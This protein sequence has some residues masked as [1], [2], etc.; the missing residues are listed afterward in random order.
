MT[1]LRDT[2]A[3]SDGEKWAEQ[4]RLA[5]LDGRALLDTLELPPDDMNTLLIVL[6]AAYYHWEHI[7]GIETWAQFAK[8]KSLKSEG[9]D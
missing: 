8:P 3:L 7:T 2:D 4:V 5:I 1:E 9:N 6:E